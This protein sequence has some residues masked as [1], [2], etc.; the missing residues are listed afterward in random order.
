MSRVEWVL[1]KTKKVIRRKPKRFCVLLRE[2]LSIEHFVSCSRLKMVKETTFLS[3]ES[4]CRVIRRGNIGHFHGE[5][6]TENEPSM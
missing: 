2:D 6:N 1:S 5:T 4:Y 3:L